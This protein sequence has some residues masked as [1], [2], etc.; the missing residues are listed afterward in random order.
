MN[1]LNCVS[2]LLIVFVGVVYV[3][4]TH[5]TLKNETH[6]FRWATGPNLN[7]ALCATAPV[8]QHHGN[9]SMHSTVNHSD[10]RE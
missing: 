7:D 3:R 8:P 9:N 1:L 5:K 2:Q 6:T 10:P 4:P